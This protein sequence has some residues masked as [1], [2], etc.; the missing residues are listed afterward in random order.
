MNCGEM[1]S[2][3][4]KYS[5]H[6]K[7]EV[8]KPVQQIALNENYAIQYQ[9]TY[10]PYLMNQYDANYYNNNNQNICYSNKTNI[11]LFNNLK[12]PVNY[13]QQQHNQLWPTNGYFQ[14]SNY[15]S[16]SLSSDSSSQCSDLD[17][18]EMSVDSTPLMQ[19]DSN[20]AIQS[21]SHLIPNNYY[22]N[23]V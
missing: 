19:F 10:Q 4:E 15:G 8:I 6:K 20:R 23:F 13:I 7:E 12:T 2:P 14:M 16:N 21:N 22:N 17:Y 9:A 18:E 5:S 3:K 1:S 11:P